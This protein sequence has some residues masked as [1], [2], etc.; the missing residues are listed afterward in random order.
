MSVQKRYVMP[1]SRVSV[2]GRNNYDFVTNEG[3]SIPAGRSKAKGIKVS[4]KFHRV[5]NKL[6]TGFDEM[7]TNP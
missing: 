6:I 4:M 2:Q 5:E 3:T 7:T 1:V